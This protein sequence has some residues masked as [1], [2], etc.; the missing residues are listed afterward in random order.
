MSSNSGHSFVLGQFS[1]PWPVRSVFGCFTV[2]PDNHFV[3]ADTVISV[4][5]FPGTG[6]WGGVPVV[7]VIFPRGGI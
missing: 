6:F 5:A 2:Y 7:S 3:A 4:F 1:V